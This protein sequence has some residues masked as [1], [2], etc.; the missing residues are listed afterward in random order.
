MMHKL[1]RTKNIYSCQNVSCFPL[2]ASELLPASWQKLKK[3]KIDMCTHRHVLVHV[4]LTL[5]HS[6]KQMSLWLVW[7]CGTSQCLCSY[8]LK[9]RKIHA[10]AK[11]TPLNRLR[12]W[13]WHLCE[14]RSTKNF[15]FCHNRPLIEYMCKKITFRRWWFILVGRHHNK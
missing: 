6:D 3:K 12:W 13:W 8:I 1:N 15:M 10:H 9:I 4:L 14:Y 11:I 7:S 5:E 2:K